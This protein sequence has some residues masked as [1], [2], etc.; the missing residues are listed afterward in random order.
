MRKVIYSMMVSLDGFVEG[1]NRELDWPVIDEELHTFVNDQ[2]NSVDTYLYGRRMYEL[3]AGAWPTLAEDAAQP[4]YIRDFGRIWNATP[5]LVFSST[6]ERVEWNS[7]LVRE[8]IAD[9]ITELKEQP[10]KDL[11]VGGANI[12]ATLVRRGLIDEYRPFVHPVVLGSGTPMIPKLDQPL[13]LQLV[14]TRRFGTGVVY[15]RYKI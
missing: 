7:T 6:L 11:E 5:K 2:Q 8:N 10:G 12:A 13:K 1:P 14:E 4:Q 15:V 3:M 9:V